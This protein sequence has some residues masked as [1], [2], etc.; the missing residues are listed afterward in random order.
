[1]WT[2][3]IDLLDDNTYALFNDKGEQVKQ[4]P[5]T[6]QMR[7][8]A[9]RKRRSIRALIAEAEKVKVDKPLAVQVEGETVVV[10]PPHE[11]EFDERYAAA[12]HD[13]PLKEHDHPH[14]HPELSTFKLAIEQESRSRYQADQE[15]EARYKAHM[16]PEL[17]Q[18]FHTHEDIYATLNVINGRITLVEGRIPTEAPAH[19]HGDINEAISALRSEVTSLRG[20]IAGLETRFDEAL[21]RAS[22]ALRS[23]MQDIQPKG[24][25]A[26]KADLESLT[27]RKGQFIL[28]SDQEVNGKH[29]WTLEEA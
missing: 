3:K 7:D 6:Q 19:Q 24:D 17:A 23:E 27:K 14:S 20:V 28:L 16:H 18:A 26:T 5:I 21:S 22:S 10:V 15:Q 4:A 12:E 2:M 11:H 8:E 1:M 29:R 9:K 13:H 25:Y